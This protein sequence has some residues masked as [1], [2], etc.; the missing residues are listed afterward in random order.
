VFF[1]A[2][3]LAF[4]IFWQDNIGAKAAREIENCNILAHSFLMIL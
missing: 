2:F 4:I 1:E 3:N